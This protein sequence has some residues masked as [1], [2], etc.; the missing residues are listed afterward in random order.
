MLSA[1]YK[2]QF[3]R[4]SIL[5][6]IIIACGMAIMS[7]IMRTLYIWD[8]ALYA[9]NSLEM[10]LSGD[11]LTHTSNFTPSD[12]NTKP[13]L[14]LWLQAI[15]MKLFG[16]NEF[17]LRFPTLLALFG[18]LVSLYY[19]L[20]KHLSDV[21]PY[22]ILL[23]IVTTPGL[24]MPHVFLSG[25]LDGLLVLFSTLSILKTYEISISAQIKNKQLY[26]LG[27]L[28]Y[29]SFMT[30]STAIL[31][32]LP[33]MLFILAYYKKL[34]VLLKSKHFYLS[35]F[36]FV[37]LIIGYYTIKESMQPGTLK[38]VFFSEVERLYKNIMPWHQRSF[39]FYWVRIYEY[40]NPIYLWLSLFVL[41]I[42]F[43][44]KVL[45][46]KKIVFSLLLSVLIYILVISIPDSKLDWYLAPALSVW[47]LFLGIA[48]SELVNH[49]LS[50]LVDRKIFQMII[51]V[52]L[53]I[54]AVYPVYTLQNHIDRSNSF[55]QNEEKEM[56]FF[57]NLSD[58]LRPS[59]VH[60]LSNYPASN[61][62]NHHNEVITFYQKA[63]KEKNRDVVLHYSTESLTER[64]TVIFRG[65]EQ[66]DSVLQEFEISLLDSNENGQLVVLKTKLK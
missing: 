18:T 28:V 23:L 57:L 22:I 35:I 11:F 41:P 2:R 8:E 34:Q 64:D 58:S 25:D 66:R 31:L 40:L 15:S 62:H 17:A 46:H 36:L 7:M 16:A 61:G 30:K 39:W 20:K 1:Q 59:T 10:L 56:T 47:G 51:V 49:I 6:L 42:Y 37:A 38:V 9:N 29:L 54:C 33:S 65:Q 4:I 27:L 24:I 19:F 48:L 50:Q 55:F 32:V 26:I 5:I 53:L 60:I 21:N 45:K 52:T 44:I 43:S 13:P 63:L 12:L 3:V 14:V